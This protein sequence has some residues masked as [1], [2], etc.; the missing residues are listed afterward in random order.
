MLIVISFKL[1]LYFEVNLIIDQSN[2]FFV[3]YF[4]KFRWF[5]ACCLV[6]FI[7]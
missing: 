7:K 4:L 3:I 6:W 1:R 5:I 2:Y